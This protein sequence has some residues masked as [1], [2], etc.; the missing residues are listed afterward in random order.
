MWQY[1]E[2]D[3][4][5]LELGALAIHWYAISYIVGIVLVWWTIDNRNTRHNLGWSKEAL[6]DLIS[7]GVFGVILGGRMGYMLFYGMDQLIDNPLSLF[8]FWQGGM[9]FHGGLL[10]VMVAVLLYA[11]KNNKKF[12][13]LMDLVSPS[14]PLALGCGRIGNFINGE[15]PG[16]VS[17][18]PWAVVYPG[19]SVTRHPSSLYQAVIEGLVLFVVL[20]VFASRSRPPMAVSGMFLFAYGLLRGLTEL[21]R[22]PDAHIGFVA[23]GWITTGQLLSLPMLLCGL[24][25]LIISYRKV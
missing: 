23:F 21:F 19:D 5:A 17:D 25:I 6:K 4:V 2:L 24:A 9:S 22:E 7:Y 8:K 16:R 13:G 1:P 14:V 20:W 3:P 15:L 12:F 11:K 10:G 18:L